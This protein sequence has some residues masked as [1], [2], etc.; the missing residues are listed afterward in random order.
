[1]KN[2]VRYLLLPLLLLGA[3][4]SRA[5]APAPKPGYTVVLE[6][7]FDEQGV[8]EEAKVFQSDD[9]TGD[10]SLEQLAMNLAQQDKQTPRQV[11]GKAVKFKARRPF[12]FPV[13]GDQGAEAN[14]NRPVLRAGHQVIP[15]YPENLAAKGEVGGAIIELAIRA[16]GKVEAV[17]PLRSSH[18]EFAEA[19][20]RALT[21]WVF[22][23]DDSPG[24]PAVSHWRAAIGFSMNGRPVELKWRLAPRPSI[25]GFIVGRLPPDASPVEIKELPLGAPAA[26]A[27]PAEKK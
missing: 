24:A 1:M 2:P 11:D 26:P 21:Q 27:A 17:R 19:S 7:T 13:E 16:D 23:P 20:M 5:Q 18:P 3:V 22:L 4:T 12:N 6:I 15:V 25:G 10:L 8:P 9:P 14:S